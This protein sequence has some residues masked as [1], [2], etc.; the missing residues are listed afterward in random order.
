M[1]LDLTEIPEHRTELDACDGKVR[2]SDPRLAVK[3][4]ARMSRSKD[5]RLTSYR[6]PYCAAWHVGQTAGRRRRRG[7]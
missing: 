4:A 6:C 5:K 3:V 1:P 7:G 2:F